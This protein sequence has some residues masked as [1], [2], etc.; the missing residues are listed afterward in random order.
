VDNVAAD[1][2]RHGIDGNVRQVNLSE[3]NISIVGTIMWALLVPR[4]M[5]N[6][7]ME[8]MHRV[9]GYTEDAEKEE[10]EA[11]AEQYK[12]LEQPAEQLAGKA[13][14]PMMCQAIRDPDLP[15]TLAKK[16]S[17]ALISAGR[18][19]EE[20]VLHALLAEIREDHYSVRT[21]SIETFVGILS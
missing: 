21:Y 19:A 16:A 3:F 10:V 14:W 7:A 1:L 6:K 9:Y 11:V 12:F 13:Y 15:E 18:P 20:T 8:T 5:A 17:D 4:D 2:A